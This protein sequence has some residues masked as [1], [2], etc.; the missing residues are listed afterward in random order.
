M[1]LHNQ[2]P[3]LIFHVLE[4]DVAQDA[5]VVD[6]DINP[7]KGLDS[8]VDD[9]VAILYRV[10]VCDGLAASRC[11][12]FDNRVGSLWE[13]EVSGFEYSRRSVELTLLPP[14]SP[15]KEPPKS[16]TTTLAPREAKK[17]AYALPSPPPAPVTTT[18]WPS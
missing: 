10:V 9:L 11:D 2:V 16:L 15:L 3:I 1:D 8:G 12:L 14:P 13:Q 18:V 4:T 17:S 5:C 6:E 7:A